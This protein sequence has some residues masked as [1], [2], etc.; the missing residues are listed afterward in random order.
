MDLARLGG[1][2]SADAADEAVLR[3]AGLQTDGPALLAF[4]RQ[5]TLSQDQLVNLAAT[6]RRLGDASYAIRE[7]ASADLAAAGRSALAPLQQALNDPDLEVARRAERCLKHLESARETALILAASRLMGKRRPAG[8][9]EV[10]LD[11]LPFADDPPVEDELLSSLRVVGFSEGKAGPVLKAALTDKTPARR[12]AAALLLGQGDGVEERALVR[13]LLADADARVRVRA[14]Q[15]LVGGGDK[16][17]VPALVALLS[18]APGDLAWQA[19]D[20]LCRLAGDQAPAVSLGAGTDAE[21]RRCRKAWAAWWQRQGADFELAKLDLERRTLGLTLIVAYTGYN[22]GHGRVWERGRD[23]QMRWEINDVTGPLDAQLLPG[24]R[25]LIAEYNGQR[26]TERDRTGQV[27]WEYRWPGQQPLGCQRLRDGHTMIAT[28]SEIREVTAEGK[29]VAAFAD[30]G[31]TILSFQKL[32]NGHLIYLTYQ[33]A[34]TELDQAGKKVKTLT[35]QRPNEGLVSI[36]ALPGGHYLVPVTAAGKIVELDGD[37]K[38]IRHWDMPHATA[39]TR[40]PNGNVLAC[41]NIGQRVVE[42]TPA[43]KVV[44]EQRVEGRVFRVRYR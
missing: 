36:E 17:A 23:G 37:G 29:V 1:E 11:Y 22:R 28:N 20:H 12:A 2:D 44:W 3:K 9:A 25:V 18:E 21:R 16:A 4:F 27:V 41:S 35:I 43:G 34:L 13:P 39:A 40:L 42:F 19:E 38:Q 26:V 32:R 33:G 7:Q 30:P 5:R 14:A 10:L 8:A 31:S 15:G 24:N 6:V